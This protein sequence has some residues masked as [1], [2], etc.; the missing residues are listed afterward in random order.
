[1]VAVQRAGL[2]RSAPTT[3]MANSLKEPTI[4]SS[5]M[6]RPIADGAPTLSSYAW[7]EVVIRRL[8]VTLPAELY[9]VLRLGIDPRGRCA[10]VWKWLLSN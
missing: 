10:P 8:E 2:L 7:A 9:V 3:L 5:G 1:M 4:R 6:P